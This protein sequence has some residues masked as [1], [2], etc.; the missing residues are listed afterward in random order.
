MNSTFIK[1]FKDVLR[2]QLAKKNSVEIDGFGRFTVVH[3][4]Q[5]QKKYE[6]GRVVILPPADILEF[7]SQIGGS[8]ED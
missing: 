1:A 5:S 3:Q 2:E 4:G 6:N 8:D 7:K